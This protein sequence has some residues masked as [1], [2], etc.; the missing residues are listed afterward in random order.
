MSWSQLQLC[1]SYLVP[2]GFSQWNT[3]QFVPYLSPAAICAY[4][5]YVSGSQG[6]QALFR[7][8]L[9]FR[10][11]SFDVA[12]FIDM[13]WNIFIGRGGQAVL[14]WISYRVFTDSL[15]R[16]METTPVPYDL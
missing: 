7:L 12:K 13:L 8:D 15:M 3:A 1:S 11:M 6:V 9:V 4:Q 14:G 16:I 5:S 10:K 2:W